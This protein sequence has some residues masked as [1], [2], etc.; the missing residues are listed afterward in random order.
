MFGSPDEARRVARNRQPARPDVQ[1]ARSEVEPAGR[2]L[3]PD[4]S[5]VDAVHCIASPATANAALSGPELSLDRDARCRC[6]D[7]RDWSTRIECR[8]QPTAARPPVET[9]VAKA[10]ATRKPGLSARFDAFRYLAQSM[11]KR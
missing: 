5:N 2:E 9:A 11:Q 8:S 3:N 10:K 6:A 4:D 1:P 7:S